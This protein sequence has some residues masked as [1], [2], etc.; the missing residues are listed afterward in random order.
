[1]DRARR[2]GGLEKDFD[3][4][5]EAVCADLSFC[6][7]E[8]ANS[9]QRGE[10]RML[11]RREN[12]RRARLRLI[13]YG[14]CFLAAGLA[15]GRLPADSPNETKT[16]RAR[17]EDKLRALSKGSSAKDA[18]RRGISELPLS[19][20]T[21]AEGKKVEGILES[22]SVFRELPAFAFEVDPEVHR[23][24]LDHPD[25]AVSIWR[26]MKISKFQMTELGPDLFA[27]ADD[28][29]TTGRIEVLHRDPHQLL[30]VC[31]GTVQ[32][33]ILPGGIKAR[34]LLHLQWDFVKS[35][36][37][38]TWSRNRLRMYVA[39]PSQAVETAAKL[40]SPLANLIIDRNL[41]EVCLFVHLMSTA[42]A[43]QPGWVE[44]IARKMEGVPPERPRELIQ[45]TVR[46]FVDVRK[47]ELAKRNA[48]DDISLEEIIQPL[49]RP[50][51]ATARK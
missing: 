36:D 13:C 25:V 9:R 27:I 14:L 8:F 48:E 23:F 42:M 44:H 22:L 38:Q 31:E 15:P 10:W 51:T 7:G 49:T 29:G 26:A 40:V 43:H 20:L 34:S 50:K 28:E 47:R 17:L 39:F 6:T 24:F 16:K 3:W 32:S 33:P 21:L 35:P 2:A 30:L 41:R 18:E 4:R 19:Q 12:R 5:Q 46:V 37:G 45:L 11:K 1:M